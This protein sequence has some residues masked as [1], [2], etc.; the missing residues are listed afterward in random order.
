VEQTGHAIAA[1]LF[2]DG[3][4]VGKVSKFVAVAGTSANTTGAYSSDGITWTAASMQT[5]ATWVDV[6]FG[7]QKFVAVSSDSTTVRISNDGELWDQTGTLTTTGFTAIAY[8]KNRFVAIKSGTNVT[9]HATSTTV[10]GTWTAGTLPSSSNWNSIAYG[11][12]RFVAVSNTS[13]TIA[14]YSLDGITWT[15]STLPSTA[16]WTKVTYGQGVF[17]AVSTTTAAATSPDG[18]TWTART[19][20]TAASGFSAVTFGNRNRYGLFVGVGAGT[21]DVATYIRT[22]ATATGRAK[23][24]QDKLFQVNITEPGSG[25]DTVPTITFTDPNN[26]YEAPTTVRKNSGVLANPSFVNRGAQYVTG[27]GEVDVGDG[28]SDIFQPGSFVATRRLSLQPV[29]GSNVVFTL[30]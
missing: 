24:A 30:T 9:N 23:V 14:A 10:T 26:T 29:P 27:S 7:G 28:Y 15:A 11:N 12:N 3:S 19:T 21:G 4:T 5:S 8:G 2:D 1:G 16:Q 22:G 17:L 13:G 6:A 20:S 18:I 25:Y